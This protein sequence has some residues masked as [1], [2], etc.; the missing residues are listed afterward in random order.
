[1]V[2]CGT[3]LVECIL[4]GLLSQEGKKVLHVDRNPF[5]GGE[6]ASL[7]LT[8]LWKLF[9]PGKNS[10]PELGQNRD[11][12]ID[13][14]PKYI[15]SGGKLVKIL[16]KTRVSK[17]LEWKSIDGTYVFQTKEKGFFTKGGYKIE[18]VP[19]TDTEALKSDLMG[20]FEK[21][22]CKKFFT[23]VQGFEPGNPKTHEGVNVQKSTK[24]ML[25][26]FELEPNT[27]DFIG[28]A[29]A[30]YTD[31]QFMQMPAIRVIDKIKLYMDSMGRY[32]DSPFIYPIYGLGG[33]PEGFS[34]ISAVNGGTFMLNTDINEILFDGGKVVGVKSNGEVAK[35]SMVI[36]DPTYVL[37]AG[38][39]D[40]VKLTERVLRCICILDH[41]IPNTN[42]MPSVQIIIPQKQ[43]NRKNDIYIM[44]V[45]SVHSVCKKDYYIAIISTT[46]ETANPEA[47]IEIAFEMLG[48]VKEKFLKIY[49]RY[50]PTKGDISDG[51][52]ISESFD[53]TSHFEN[54]TENVLQ[55]YKKI[56]GKDLDLVNLPEE[57][58]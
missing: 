48:P 5:Y 11:W 58:E 40:R 36:C 52:V 49:D 3:G 31:E 37:N 45:S 32:G 30:L 53:A 1:M 26:K 20:L 18:K 43:L 25:D 51:L 10:P 14:I 44:M 54:E 55:L 22:R 7:N 4:S 33:I 9:R 6:G 38:L 56:T 42:N 27:I 34:R 39:K 24:E 8:N 2:V 15:I 35:C 50:V 47:E 17:Y 29:V 41:P 28:H 46:I 16:L 19:A 21:R 57:V 13:L 23:F 12:N